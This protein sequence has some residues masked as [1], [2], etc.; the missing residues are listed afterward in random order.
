MPDVVITIGPIDVDLLRE[1]RDHLL[2]LVW[3]K[4]NGDVSTP[5]LAVIDGIVNL[6]D[7]MLDKAEGF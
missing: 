4:S 5:D 7:S 6:L 2:S 3:G 1:Q